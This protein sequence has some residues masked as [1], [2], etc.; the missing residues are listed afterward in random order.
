M[1]K[2]IQNRLF[3]QIVF[4]VYNIRY[5]HKYMAIKKTQT[6]QKLTTTRTKTLNKKPTVK[7]VVSKKVMVKKPTVTNKIVTKNPTII[8]K[9]AMASKVIK[10]AMVV[11]KPVS[12]PKTFKTVKNDIKTTSKQSNLMN[13]LLRLDVLIALSLFFLL[14]TNIITVAVIQ[15]DINDLQSKVEILETMMK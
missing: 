14:I 2:I 7:K 15:N 1:I 11:S 10:P 6:K 12:K 8:K 4:I 3:V 5:K 9:K 13:Y